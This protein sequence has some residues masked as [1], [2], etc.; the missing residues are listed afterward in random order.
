MRKKL[1]CICLEMCQP[2]FI[3]LQETWLKLVLGFCCFAQNSLPDKKINKKKANL[4]ID[5]PTFSPLTSIYSFGFKNIYSMLC[6]EWRCDLW[7]NFR[8]GQ[9]WNAGVSI[10][11]VCLQDFEMRLIRTTDTSKSVVDVWFGADTQINLFYEPA[12]S[13]WNDCMCQW[14]SGGWSVN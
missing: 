5:R 8:R 13:F 11:G 12:V 14:T 4:K 1:G 7:P 2:S 6:W 9:L 3:R 10:W